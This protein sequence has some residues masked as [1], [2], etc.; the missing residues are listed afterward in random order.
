MKDKP[1]ILFSMEQALSAVLADLTSCPDV[2][3]ILVFGS[4][5]RGDVTRSSD[6]DLLVVTTGR[7]YWRE[8]RIVCGVPVDFFFNPLPML[9]QRLN[10]EDV[11][12]VQGV[13]TGDVLFDRHGM[14]PSVVSQAR[15]VWESGPS[16]IT[17]WDR[18]L[19]RYRI[20]S[21]AQDLEDATTPGPDT[22]LLATHLVTRA[23]E[24]YLTLHRRWPVAT[25][26]LLVAIESLDVGLA[27]E[28]REFYADVTNTARA[29]RIADRVL[30][31]FGGRTAEYRSPKAELPEGM[32]DTD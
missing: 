10:Q 31:P 6:I 13:A 28:T 19:V 12:V 22:V 9:L 17:D 27:K 21:L 24:A 2:S 14:M 1:E 15:H 30:E 7:K 26:R 23:L 25:R 29:I 5:Q 32:T 18:V 4:A 3:A 11:V 20:G 8:G 16:L